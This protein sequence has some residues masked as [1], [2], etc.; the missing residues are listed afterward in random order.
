LKWRI[1]TIRS[2]ITLFG[3]V[4]AL[5]ISLAIGSGVFIAYEGESWLNELQNEHLA[6]YR[7][8]FELRET[9]AQAVDFLQSSTGLLS[10]ERRQQVLP[11]AHA[12]EQAL[13]AHW[14]SLAALNVAGLLD[15]EAGKVELDAFISQGLLPVAEQVA[16]EQRILADFTLTRDG[17]PP[18]ERFNETLS[19]GIAVL[20]NDAESTV[21]QNV[22][23]MKR[24]KVGIS[25]AG[26]ALWL[27]LTGIAVRMIS[28]VIKPLQQAKEFSLQ[29]AAGNLK[30]ET[31][32]I[33]ADETGD[34]LTAMRLMRLSLLG[35]VGEIYRGIQVVTPAA[36]KISD[37]NHSLSARIDKQASAIQQ[38]AA[39]MEEI[40]S[41]V[42]HNASNAHEA[43]QA[44][45]GGVDRIQTA[46]NVVSALM[47]SMNTL[48]AQSE[49]MLTL[50]RRR[51][52]VNMGE[53]LR[54]LPKR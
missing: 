37:N 47:A 16:S 43:H 14:D 53:A 9:T 31:G 24:F 41:T 32:K 48:K 49:S 3:G 26:I 23:M 13:Q 52:R 20:G 18:V 45:K 12:Y 30:A 36:N 5:A 10:D 50:V 34:V 54:W 21:N 6:G 8:L 28:G 42:E 17:L 38:T 27:A 22:A 40:A 33:P 46:D 51:V 35:L 7:T 25:I 29:V 11:K 39:A 19:A 4:S 15:L 44:S 2:R 1:T